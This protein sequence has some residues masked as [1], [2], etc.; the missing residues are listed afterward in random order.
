MT[1][2]A[3]TARRCQDCLPLAFGNQTLKLILCCQHRQRQVALFCI[4]CFAPAMFIF[5]CCAQIPTPPP[6][7]RV[8][9][10]FVSVNRD[11]PYSVASPPWFRLPYA[12]HLA[13][14]PLGLP[15]CASFGGGSLSWCYFGPDGWC[16]SQKPSF[17]F[18]IMSLEFWRLCARSAVGPP[19]E[20][21]CCDI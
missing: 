5:F 10:S 12:P 11:L 7:G 6:A 20:C 18:E 13:G 17:P 19:H 21:V 1:V 15:R 9:D 2:P 4:F 3:N 14:T 16:S 8:D